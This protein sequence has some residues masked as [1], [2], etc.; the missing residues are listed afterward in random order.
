MEI[1]KI[2]IQTIII[3]MTG[4]LCACGGKEPE[5][6]SLSGAREE[7]SLAESREDSDKKGRWEKGYDLP[8][9]ENERKE[10]EADLR[11]A[12]ELTRDIYQEADKGDASN[13]V[14][15]EEVLIQLLKLRT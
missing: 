13:V 10:A 6:F 9:D 3:V 5:D 2:Y 14:L 8:V 12:L 1:K 4:F 7:S 11:A 15:S